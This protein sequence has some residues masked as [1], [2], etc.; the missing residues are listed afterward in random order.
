MSAPHEFHPDSVEDDPTGMRDLLSSLPDPGPMPEDLVAR[1]TASLASEQARPALDELA[2]RRRPHRILVA[3]AA[4]AVVVVGGGLLLRSGVPGSV[5]ASVTS[6]GSTALSAGSQASPVDG[7]LSRSDTEAGPVR[8]PAAAT[9]VLRSGTA[10]AASRLVEQ[11][12]GLGATFSVKAA[13]APQAPAR[14][15]GTDPSTVLGT[16]TG[17][18]ACALALGIPD[19]EGIVVD[20]G[21]VDGRP[22]AVVVARSASG[23][24]TAY[25]VGASCGPAGSDLVSGPVPL[26]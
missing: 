25:A 15:D 1:I 22:G 10:Y 12:A 13:P 20:V 6:N 8:G 19:D 23:A 21:S 9:V 14:A 17:A 3:A 7:S 26:P 5:L 16:A 4:A 24:L 11:A 18:R 2:R